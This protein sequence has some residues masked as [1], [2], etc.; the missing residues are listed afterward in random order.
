[1]VFDELYI[2][3]Q[4][5][6]LVHFV[7]LIKFNEM[8]LNFV[9]WTMYS[10]LF[11][12]YWPCNIKG[13]KSWLLFIMNYLYIGDTDS[14]V[15]MYHLSVAPKTPCFGKLE[16]HLPH[17]VQAQPLWVF[18]CINWAKRLL[19]Y[20]HVGNYKLQGTLL[21]DIH[22]TSSRAHLRCMLPDGRQFASSLYITTL[23]SLSDYM[24]KN[25]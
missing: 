11:Q 20:V 25:N 22:S 17:P 12:L 21:K 2:K 1:M 8:L 7:I 3:K 4:L 15:N 24:S 23:S 6:H 13:F 16:T 9:M 10:F 5:I 14:H 18:T 19:K